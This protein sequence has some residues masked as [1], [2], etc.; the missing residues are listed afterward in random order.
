MDTPTGPLGVPKPDSWT[1]ERVISALAGAVVLGSL[2]LG[3]AHSPRWRILTSFVGANLIMN[4]LAGWCPTSVVLY[5]L[6]LRTTAECALA[7]PAKAAS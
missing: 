7:E 2:A 5:K 6:G 1:L 3:R 4:A